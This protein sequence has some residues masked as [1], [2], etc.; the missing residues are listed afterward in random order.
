MAAPQTDLNLEGLH[1]LWS[2][3]EQQLSGWQSI[4]LRL[5]S[6]ANAP[7]VFTIDQGNGGQPQKRAQLTLN[8]TTGEVV[9]WEPFSS[10]TLGRRLRMVLQFA[11]TGEVAGIIGQ[12]IAGVVSAG[13]SLLVYTGLALSWRRFR[14]WQARR[15]S[16]E[17]IETTLRTE[18]ADEES[19]PLSPH[20]QAEA[21]GFEAS[22]RPLSE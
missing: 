17:S 12:T 6:S 14:A 13:A 7:L 9:R 20:Y 21:Q 10:M 4:S 16:Q 18:S 19:G 3:A 11:H 15:R 1:T 2:R 8:R 22:S 5:P